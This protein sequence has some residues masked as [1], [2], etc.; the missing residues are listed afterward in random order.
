MAPDLLDTMMSA[1]A[2]VIRDNAEALTALDQAI[3]D[4]DHGINMTRGFAAIEAEKAAMAAMALPEALQKIGMTLVMNVGGAS[5]PLYGSYFIAMGRAIPPDPLTAAAVAEA[6]IA[7]ALAVQQRGKSAPGEKT[8]LDV[9][10][11]VAD[12]VRAAAKA[13]T[14]TADMLTAVRDAA[15]CGLESTRDMLATKGRASYLGERSV[16]HL[17]PG[18]QSSQLLVESICNVVA[19]NLAAAKVEDV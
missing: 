11:P 7:G 1:A 13:G 3:G 17:D 19:A 8:M 4:G 10:V 5:G 14:P 9:L 16:G 2:A 6:L 12:A 18:A 15:A